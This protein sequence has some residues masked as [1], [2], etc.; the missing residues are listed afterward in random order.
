MGRESYAEG[1]CARD[2]GRDKAEES[3]AHVVDGALLTLEQR[4]TGREPAGRCDRCREEAASKGSNDRE[5][6]SGQDYKGVG[7]GDPVAGCQLCMIKAE[8]GPQEPKADVGI[9]CC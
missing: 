4:Y 8:I 7:G 3:E 2:G 1:L 6:N 9:G 5:R